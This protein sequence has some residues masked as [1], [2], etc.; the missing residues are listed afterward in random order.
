MVLEEGK[1]EILV[2]KK[3]EKGASRRRS[4]AVGEGAR[5]SGRGAAPPRNPPNPDFLS[6]TNP[7]PGL[8]KREHATLLPVSQR[9]CYYTLLNMY[10][11]LPLG[12]GVILM[13]HH[14]K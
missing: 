14:P 13:G 7:V 3:I 11:K 10:S 6:A 2:E 5:N 4:R 12:P 8:A 1:R 9:S